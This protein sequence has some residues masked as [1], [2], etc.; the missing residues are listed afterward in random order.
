M[1]RDLFLPELIQ[2]SIITPA[3][4]LQDDLR[5]ALSHTATASA[6]RQNQILKKYQPIVENILTQQ[7]AFN[8]IL[9]DFHDFRTL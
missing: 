4:E 8:I 1:A 7:E 2:S 9:D 3:K 5:N 6:S